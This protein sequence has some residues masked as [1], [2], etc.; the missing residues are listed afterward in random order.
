MAGLASLASK[1]G[2]YSKP[3][4]LSAVY[5]ITLDPQTDA[6]R[7]AATLQYFPESL[8]DSK[9]VSWQSKEVPGGSLPIYQWT[10]SGERSLSFTAQF[11]TDIDLVGATR[12]INAAVAATD[13]SSLQARIKNAGQ[14][15]YNVDIRAAV[16]WLRSH[17]LPTYD[18]S[19]RSVAPPKVMVYIPRSGIGLVGGSSPVSRQNVDAVVCVMTSCEVTWE[20]YFPSGAPRIASVSLAFAQVPQYKGQVMFPAASQQMLDSFN[21]NTAQGGSTSFLGYQPKYVSTDLSSIAT[22]TGVK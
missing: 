16:A 18:S 15:R 22:L 13:F 9:S 11:S 8:S 3:A 6:P 7:F 20:K 14:S 21:A 19:G 17:M 10:G 1:I 5:L 2:Q 12:Q 4:N